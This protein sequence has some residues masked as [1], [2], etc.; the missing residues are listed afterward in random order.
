MQATGPPLI[1]WAR[2]GVRILIYTL[3]EVK[4]N[5]LARSGLALTL[6]LI[7]LTL[8][9]GGGVLVLLVLRNEVVHVALCLRGLHLVHALAC[10][11]M[12]ESLAA[13]HGG[14][15][16]GHSLEHLL[17]G[18]GIARERDSHLQ[19]LWWDVADGS[20]D[21]LR[22]PL[23]EVRAV[24][25]AHVEHLLIDLLGG[26]APAEERGG[27]QVAAM[28]RVGGAHHVLS[29][30][31]LLSQLRHG[32]GAVLLRA[33]ACERRETCHKEMETWEGDQID[34]DLPQVAVQLAWEAQ[35]A[36]HAADGPH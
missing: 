10:V 32:Q 21:V 35:A 29:V 28:A 16:L 9:L 13:E 24:L 26:H 14:E 2:A 27:G 31:H 12:Q 36:G 7:E 34:R 11:P 22:D 6:L 1:R 33:A 17:D 25:V 15:I 5:G 18:G 19:A 23:D 8:L 3:A 20:L 4:A 30:E